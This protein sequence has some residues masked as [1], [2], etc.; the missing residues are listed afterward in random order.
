MEIS[1]Q[2]TEEVPITLG[3][4][5]VLFYNEFLNLY[6]DPELAAMAAAVV[7]NEMLGDQHSQGTITS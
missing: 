4:L 5:I 3:D 1:V 6:N 2:H 7:I